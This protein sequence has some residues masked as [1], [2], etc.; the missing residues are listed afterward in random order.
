M[1]KR[2]ILLGFGVG[3]LTWLGFIAI[4]TIHDPN[5][6]QTVSVEP[7]LE[8]TD[9]VQES[10][11]ET[12][13][14]KPIELPFG[15]QKL[16]PDYRFVALYGNPDYKGLGV[17][18]EQ[19]IEESITRIKTLA[20]EYQAL[21]DEKVI[22]TF[23]IITT[24][25]SSELTENQDYS[26]EYEI[27]KLKPWIES[28]KENNIYVILDLQPGRSTFLTQA[29]IYEELL[30]EPHV[31]L[32]LDPEWR[33]QKPNDRHLVKVGTVSSA[34]VNE[35]SN[36]LAELV[37]DNKLPQKLFM[38]H[39]FKLAMISGRETLQT[40]REELA[41]MIHMDGHG[42]LGSKVNTW[43]TIKETLPAD[44]FLGWKNFYD[45]DKPTPTPE[46]TMQQVPKPWLVTY[47]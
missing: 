10:A 21:S 19:G 30:K 44:V 32:A 36:W 22:P 1:S 17:L 29:K 20:T 43:N 6:E 5:F 38:V 41:Y 40:S 39:Q 3:L 24:I 2:P 15:G 47:Q 23:E 8:K 12:E 14:I 28:A 46:Q 11:E 4:I 34:E 16:F 13:I 45:E 37:K 25:A 27:E 33:L 7:A 31:G 9:T 18:G 26:R 42:E 35:V